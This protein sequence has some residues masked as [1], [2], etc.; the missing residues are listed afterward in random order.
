MV[1][2]HLREKNGYFHIILNY[3]DV[4]GNRRTKSVSTGL[5][6][7]G[8]K[9]RAEAMLQ[10]ARK[11]FEQNEPIDSNDILFTEYLLSWLEMMKNSVEITTYSSYAVCIKSRIIP[12]FKEFKLKLR[13][14]T[15]KH[16]QDYYQYEL[17]DKGLSP[18]T[19]IH[20]HANIRKALQH[21]FKIGLINFN[22]ADRI[23]RPQKG[24]FVGSIYDA[25]ELETLFA[26][27]KSKR[28][29]LAVLSFS[30]SSVARA[31]NSCSMV[32]SRYTIVVWSCSCPNREE[33]CTI[34]MP[35]SNQWEA[36]A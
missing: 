14:V 24:K 21:A 1:A 9:K 15:P 32:M 34:F 10:D 8:N 29:E 25:S 11:N 6:I 18:N 2:G 4:N 17:N 31:F 33:I 27:V 36:L 22:P 28:I 13:D 26:I 23:E 12:Y 20:R 19:V 35:S 16:I 5:L 30:S 7:K 3:K